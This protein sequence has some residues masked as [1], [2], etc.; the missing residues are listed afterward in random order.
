MNTQKQK[1]HLNIIDALIII[2]IIAIAAFAANVVINDLLNDSSADVEFT[3]K[4]EGITSEHCGDI[5]QG[6]KLTAGKANTYI[7]TVSAVTVLPAKR[8]VFNY[9]TSRFTETT[10]DGYYDMYITVKATLPVVDNTYTIG[11][12]CI[13]A[14]TNPGITLPFPYESAEI[15]SVRA[16]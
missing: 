8:T 16:A 2:A 12:I 4:A 15:V 10:L 11:D 6:L 9:E 5:W 13:S 14:N 3:V 1:K 7:G